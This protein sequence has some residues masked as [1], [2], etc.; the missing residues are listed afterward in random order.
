MASPFVAGAVARYIAES[1][2]PTN[3]RAD[4][5]AIKAAVIGAGV[6]QGSECGFSD[7][8]SS[9]EPLLFVNGPTFGGDGTCGDGS[10][11]NRPPVAQF[12]YE[13]VDLSCR[14]DNQSSDGDGTIVSSEWSFGDGATSSDANPTHTY[15]QDGTYDVSLTVSDD[16]GARHTTSQSVAVGAVVEPNQPPTARSPRHALT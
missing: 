15:V 8:D 1:G 4:V 3:N 7:V 6:D 12:S 2:A 10:T 5:E 11:A 13:C 9:P 14:F 16:R